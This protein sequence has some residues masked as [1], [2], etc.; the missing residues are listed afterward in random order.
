MNR[1]HHPPEQCRLLV[2]TSGYSYAEWIDAGFYPPRTP[3]GRMLSLYAQTFPIT[4]LN[5]TWYQMPKAEA[6]ERM[7]KQVSPSFLF[8]AKLNRSVT[9]DVDFSEW[10]GRVREYR[11]GISPLQQTGQLAAVLLQLP[12]SFHRV[13]KNRRYLAELLNEL[14]GLPVAVEFRHDSWATDRVFAELEQRK[15]ALVAVD[16][17]DVTRLFPKLDVVT[18]PDF[19]YVRFHGR[20][21]RGWRSG[22]MQKQFDYDY[23]VAELREWAHEKIEKMSGQARRGFLFFNNHVRAQAPRNAE[24]LMGQL[25]EHQFLELHAE[26]RARNMISG[27]EIVRPLRP[28]LAAPH[29]K[30]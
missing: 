24:M 10:R 29:Q 19:F 5:Y 16:T 30:S 2:G 11:D 21:T 3:S 7:C 4:E 8:A 28:G 17:P 26:S 13:T 22:N 14:D 6:I 18:N 15:V 1:R 9:H 20:N 23:S 27:R 12:P 25:T